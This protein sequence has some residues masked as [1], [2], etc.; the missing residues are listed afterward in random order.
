MH[1][2]KYGCKEVVDL[3][4]DYVEG[5]CSPDAETLIKGHLADCPDCVA[6]VNTFRKSVVM[7]KALA[8]RDIPKDLAERL[9]RVLERRIPMPDSPPESSSHPFDRPRRRMEDE[10]TL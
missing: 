9:H 2:A 8:Y 4:S 1:E 5:S 6:F 7:T 3:L 10:D